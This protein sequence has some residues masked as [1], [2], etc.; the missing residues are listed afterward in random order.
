MSLRNRTI[1][2][3]GPLYVCT[4]HMQLKNPPLLFRKSSR[5]GGHG[6]RGN[7][8]CWQLQDWSGSLVCKSSVNYWVKSSALR[9]VCK[10][11]C[12]IITTLSRCRRLVNNKRCLIF[13]LSKV[14]V[15]N[16]VTYDNMN[17]KAL[18]LQHLLSSLVATELRTSPSFIF[19]YFR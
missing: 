6:Y 18:V 2:N 10:H 7:V 17:D 15:L 3:G 1:K 16:V 12:L 14:T 19:L 8:P 9:W 11:S 4:T 13:M 5:F